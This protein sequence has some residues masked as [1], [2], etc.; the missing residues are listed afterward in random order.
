ME[1]ICEVCFLWPPGP[2]GPAGPALGGGAGGASAGR[3]QLEWSTPVSS[4]G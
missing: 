2:A 1:L 4:A 3:D